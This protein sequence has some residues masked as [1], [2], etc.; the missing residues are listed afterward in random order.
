VV[1]GAQQAYHN[2]PHTLAS[3]ADTQA[4]AAGAPVPAPSPIPPR[5]APGDSNPCV[6]R[7]CLGNGR[8][9]VQV[10]WRDPRHGTTGNGVAAPLTDDT[11]AFWFFAPENLELMVKVLD[12]RPVNGHFWVFFGSLSDVEYTLAVTDLATGAMR[13]YHNPPFTLASRADTS[14]F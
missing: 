5:S 1:T 11:G 10:A 13:T 7:L 3:R 14:A 9:S 2:L 8:F 6:D 4:F 12:G